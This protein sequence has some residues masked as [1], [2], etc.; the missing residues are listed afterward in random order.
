[1]VTGSWNPGDATQI[2]PEAVLFAVAPVNQWRP[3][4]T[5]GSSIPVPAVPSRG[6]PSQSRWKLADAGNPGAPIWT[7]KF[8]L[9]NA[10][11]LA[12]LGL[13]MRTVE[14][15]TD[16]VAEATVGLLPSPGPK[17]EEARLPVGDPRQDTVPFAPVRVE[18]DHVSP[19]VEETANS[20]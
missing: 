5:A 13:P 2:H 15:A 10:H 11:R 1:M 3:E 16:G 9:G 7:A 12:L 18:G 14:F 17:C 6:E 20:N 19:P 8:A 4:D